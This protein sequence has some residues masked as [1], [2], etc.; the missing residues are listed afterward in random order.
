MYATIS[1][2]QAVCPFYEGCL[3]LR[4]SIIIRDPTIYLITHVDIPTC[5]VT[6]GASFDSCQ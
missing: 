2:G 5:I 3:L 6:T 4:V 1:W